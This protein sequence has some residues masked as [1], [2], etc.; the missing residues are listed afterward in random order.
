MNLSKPDRVIVVRNTNIVLK[1]NKF[2]Y[3]FD[4]KYI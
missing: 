1:K 4:L 3:L 2:K